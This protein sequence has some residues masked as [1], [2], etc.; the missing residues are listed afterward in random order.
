ME[1]AEV[2][3]LAF[4]NE[5]T[6]YQILAIVSKTS[7]TSVPL[8][9]AMQPPI[10]K[11][12]LSLIRARAVLNLPVRIGSFMIKLTLVSSSKQDRLTRSDASPPTT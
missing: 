12:S 3:D 6:G 2:A 9:L 11:I 7:T 5:G 4:V 10:A 1:Q 8:S